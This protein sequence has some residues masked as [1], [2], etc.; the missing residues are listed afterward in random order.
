VV[1]GILHS[2]LLDLYQLPPLVHRK[3]NHGYAVPHHLDAGSSGRSSAQQT[4]GDVA[5]TLDDMAGHFDDVADTFHDVAGTL[6]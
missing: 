1:L 5:G 6:G 3:P 2:L 4:I